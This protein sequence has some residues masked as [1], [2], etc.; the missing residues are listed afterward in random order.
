M[1]I[2]QKCFDE[3]RDAI[4]CVEISAR[5]GMPEGGFSEAALKN[6]NACMFWSL[7]KYLSGYEDFYNEDWELE[8]ENGEIVEF[9]AGSLIDTLY[10]AARLYKNEATKL[11]ENKADC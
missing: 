1:V 3:L 5:G 11:Y 9:E 7:A 4:A 10:G 6:I 2:K 8:N